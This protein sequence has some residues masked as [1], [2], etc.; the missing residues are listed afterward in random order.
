MPQK[1]FS[2]KRQKHRLLRHKSALVATDNTT[3]LI[4]HKRRIKQKKVP[5]IS[6]YLESDA[7]LSDPA[8]LDALLPPP[9]M[10]PLDF[11]ALAVGGTISI[12]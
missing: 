12:S 7:A 9:G 6:N 11:V 5:A 10:F 8:E 4:S 3:P 1:F 2:T